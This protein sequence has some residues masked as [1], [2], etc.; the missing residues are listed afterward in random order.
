MHQRVRT[1]WV[2]LVGLQQ[3]PH[4]PAVE[5]AARTR[6]TAWKQAQVS[7]RQWTQQRV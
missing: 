4:Y 2:W 7:T 1:A 5:A 6:G 3:S